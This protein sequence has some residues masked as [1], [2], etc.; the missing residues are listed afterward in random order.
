MRTL[1]KPQTQALAA[2]LRRRRSIS[3]AEAR[4]VFGIERLA[5]RMHDLRGVVNYRAERKVDASG[6]RYTRYYYLGEGKVR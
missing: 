5:A 3:P 6:H 1:S 2:Y 4:T